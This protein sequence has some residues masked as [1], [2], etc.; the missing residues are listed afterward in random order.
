MA[1]YL[2]GCRLIVTQN[3][4]VAFNGYFFDKPAI[5]FGEID[6]HHIAVQTSPET[7]AADLKAA[8]KH[9]PNYA[10]F[11]WWYWQDQSIN[12]GHKSAREKIRARFEKFGWIDA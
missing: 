6:F 3:S 4:S 8:L 5:L 7:F 2:P 1:N 11:L 10:K 9:K 12:A